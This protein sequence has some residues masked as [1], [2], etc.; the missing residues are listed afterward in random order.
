MPY[1][2][3]NIGLHLNQFR[4]YQDI[5]TC[6]FDRLAA[7]VHVL[8][9]SKQ[10]VTHW[11]WRFRPNVSV[12]ERLL[13]FHTQSFSPTR[14]CYGVNRLWHIEFDESGL[15]N[16]WATSMISYKKIFVTVTHCFVLWNVTACVAYGCEQ[17]SSCCGHED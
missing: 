7:T 11:V 16:L 3:T 8:N 6:L 5:I 10:T 14:A 4:N 15:T 13:R 9:W 1:S 17:L 2:F 12:S